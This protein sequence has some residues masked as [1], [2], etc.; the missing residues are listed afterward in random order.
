MT[1]RRAASLA[2][3]QRGR[4]AVDVT[5]STHAARASEA[6]LR[7]LLM[8]APMAGLTHSAFRR[9]LGELGGCDVVHTEMLAGT[10][11]LVERPDS[12]Y[13]KRCSGDGRV[14]YQLL[15]RDERRLEEIVDRLRPCQPDGLDLN[16]A[17][18]A[19]CVRA[20]GGGVDLFEEPARLEAVLRVL[21]R[22]WPGLLSAKVR[23][24]RHPVPQWRER[25]CERLRL[26]RDAGV[27]RLTVHP[28]F[29]ADRLARPARHDLLPWVCEHAGLPVVANG[30]ITGPET[31]ARHPEHF[32]ACAGVMLG[33][34]AVV[35][36]W[37]FAAWRGGEGYV[38]PAAA[39]VWRRV[40][41]CIQADFGPAQAA[42]RL[43][44]YTGWFARNFRYGHLLA[45]Q[46]RHLA[47]AETLRARAEAF[48]AASPALAQSPPL[49]DL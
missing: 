45:G 16:C 4:S 18:P 15:L 31:L 40:A 43:R 3:W 23:L 48:L 19:A 36:P 1:G 44:Q 21:R 17:C 27:D 8:A 30:D 13:L 47:D 10:R 12:P 28:R 37:T 20:V 35:R 6:A 24:G 41:D 32:A 11:L 22:L 29:G 2:A 7:P 14:V 26:F 5:L 33:R 34:M 46:V 9:V 49:Y 42:P 39:A 38:P 25:F